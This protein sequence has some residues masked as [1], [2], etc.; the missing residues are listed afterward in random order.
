MGT[1]PLC[2]SIPSNFDLLIR[3]YLKEGMVDH[4][5]ETFELVGLVGFKPSVYTC[6]MILASM[7]KDQ[8]TGLVWSL[9]MPFS[10]TG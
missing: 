4:A 3:V 9:F 8:R 1:Y 2:S 6:N 10:C 7:V 5:L